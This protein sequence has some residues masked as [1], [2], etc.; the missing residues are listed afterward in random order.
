MTHSTPS[1][2]R[3]TALAL[4]A[5]AL[6]RPG[7]AQAAPALPCPSGPGEIVGLML[8]GTGAPAG[9]VTVFGQAFQPGHMPR[10]AALRARDTNGREFPAQ[11]DVLAVHPD[12][13]ARLGVVSL[14]PP[15]IGKAQERGVM[16]MAGTGGSTAPLDLAAA[17]S[18]R[19]AVLELASAGGQVW[20]LDL[21]AAFRSATADQ[22]WQSG[23]L[24]VQRRVSVAVPGDSLAGVTSLRV[25]A[26]VSLRSDGTL[27][28]EVWLRN[29]A[30]M[31]PG[32]GSASYGVRVLLDGRE[33]MRTGLLH[34]WQYTG[35]GRL[36]AADRG[37]PAAEPPR[38][39]HDAN[40]LAD[41]GAVPRYS[42]SGGT[43]DRALGQLAR[44]VAEG[45]WS[46]PL[47]ARGITR[48]MPATGGRA[49]IGPVTQPQALWLGTGDYR[50]ATVSIGQAE[51]AGS[52]PWHM[53]DPSV[54]GWLDVK[55]WPR[56]W[57]DGRGGPPPGGLMQNV[58][59][60]T[61]WTPD[62][63]HQPDLST[64]PFILTGRRAFLDELLAQSAWNIISLWPAPRGEGEANIVRGVQVRG[65][66]WSMRQ[67]DNAAWAAPRGDRTGDYLRGV[68]ASNWA[69]I[70]AQIPEWT[71]RQGEAHGWIPGEYGTPG[72]IAPWQQD[73]FVSTAVLSARRGNADARAVLDW[74][75]NFI[76]GRFLS[77]DRGFNPHD[78]CAYNLAMWPE[79]QPQSPFNTWARIGQETRARNMSNGNG[80]STSDGNYGALAIHSLTL[81]SELTGSPRARAALSWIVNAGAPY[82]SPAERAGTQF[83]IAPRDAAGGCR[84]PAR[85]TR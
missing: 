41:A 18:G 63:A 8:E 20:R 37:K 67:L 19:S 40:Y 16:L 32:G 60:D 66:A 38:P 56:L 46:A 11:L 34:Q 30:A 14:A 74:M 59:G 26:D 17:L 5:A 77:G 6:A 68:A 69:W 75:E 55:K 53:W 65:A 47:E 7:F 21:L 72:A 29:D 81:M 57:V 33:A 51:A 80:W 2:L 3:R 49:D 39:R 22:A 25:V 58:S 50:A 84:V 44:Q 48:N 78:G 85:G 73:Y 9:T 71:R 31:R 23:P 42:M 61:G 24:A 70:R 79:N 35:W 15:A 43:V 36:L 82:T 4:G 52:V 27:W 83:D 12:G 13:S 64:V 28:T 45:N 1:F 62:T 76:A 54:N 10:G